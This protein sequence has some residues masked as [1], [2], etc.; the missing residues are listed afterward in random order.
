MKINYKKFG[1]LYQIPSKTHK[2]DSGMDVYLSNNVTIRPF[3][4]ACIGLNFGLE[5]PIGYTG[6]FV[7][8]S[9]ISKKGL[10]VHNALVDPGYTGEV[11]LIITNC[12]SETYS[13]DTG[14]RLGSLIIIP[15]LEIEWEE[16]VELNQ[17]ERGEKGFGSSGK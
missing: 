1:N 9:S 4:T 11:H 3:E 6:Y 12:S 17:S 5:V 10:I 13:F 7:P 2:E 15:V 14:D 16:K 8:R